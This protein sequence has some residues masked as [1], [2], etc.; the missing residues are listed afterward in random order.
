MIFNY[1]SG[2]S[3]LATAISVT[4]TSVFPVAFT[5]EEA[6]KFGEVRALLAETMTR[7]VQRDPNTNMVLGRIAE[8]R[9]KLKELAKTFEQ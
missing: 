5:E 3:Y 4:N 2:A 6:S 9:G 1:G 8:G 7:I